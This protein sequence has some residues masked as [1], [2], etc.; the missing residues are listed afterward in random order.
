MFEIV[1][2]EESMKQ[3]DALKNVDVS[4][5]SVVNH[6]ANREPWKMFK[7]EEGMNED[8][9]IQS[10]LVPKGADL[11][12]S[13]QK[14]NLGWLTEVI[15]SEAVKYESYTEFVQA[16]KTSFENLS[17]KIVSKEDGI[18]AVVGN[19]KPD[20][21][22]AAGSMSLL[23]LPENPMCMPVSTELVPVSQTAG[24]V[25]YK[26][27]YGMMDTIEGVMRQAAF[28]PADRKAAV[29]KSVS[30]FNTFCD[31]WTD[32]L[33]NL[34][35]TKTKFDVS[36]LSDI[37]R[38]QKK[39]GGNPEMDETKLA[40]AIA[41]AL[42]PKFEGISKGLEELKAQ[43]TETP[44]PVVESTKTEPV[45]SAPVAAVVVPETVSKAEHDALKKAFEDFKAASEHEPET[46]P[47]AG[48]A[49]L[50][51]GEGDEGLE[52]SAVGHTSEAEALPPD[53]RAGV[54]D[55]TIFDPKKVRAAYG[56]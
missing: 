23:T 50:P 29:L 14:D 15:K 42:A 17:F 1:E 26:E 51:S 22:K 52:K 24:D 28:T 49:D 12:A 11:E 19:L 54:F 37:I 4:W 8:N 43:K 10:V 13:A 44:A 34:D 48:T 2:T 56:H 32:A 40:A 9:V 21:K 6:G 16:P 27:V 55:G 3:I 38:E 5:I 45:V 47:A 18:V 25:F 46:T 53:K 20:K 33:A 35:T 39:D 7:S 41:E 30:A 36:I 31:M